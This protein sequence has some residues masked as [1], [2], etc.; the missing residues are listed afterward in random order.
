MN[1]TKKDYRYTGWGIVP[2]R[3]SPAKWVY[4]YKGYRGFESLPLRKV[5]WR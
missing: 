3:R 2:W 1:K 5:Y 4:L